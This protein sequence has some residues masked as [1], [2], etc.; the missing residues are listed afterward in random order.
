MP[1]ETL[2]RAQIQQELSE[3]QFRLSRLTENEEW[4]RGWVQT[5][6]NE[7]QKQLARMS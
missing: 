2:A 3:L 7:K 6:I 1:E 5:A 4:F